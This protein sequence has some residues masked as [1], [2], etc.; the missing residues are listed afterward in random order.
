MDSSRFAACGDVRNEDRAHADTDRRNADRLG[1]MCLQCENKASECWS[2]VK[3]LKK[4]AK[5]ASRL[6]AARMQRRRAKCGNGH[7]K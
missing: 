7:G 3:V 6:L 5:D 2:T 4:G 1:G